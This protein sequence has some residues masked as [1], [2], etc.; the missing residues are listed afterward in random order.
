ML[1]NFILGTEVA[2]IGNIHIANISILLKENNLIEGVDYLKFGGITLLAKQSLQYPK[3]ITELINN[4]INKFTDL[5][6]LVPAK[7]FIDVL[8]NNTKLIAKKYQTITVDSKKFIKILDKDL[9]K[10]M[11]NELITKSVVTNDEIPELI[12][13]NYIVGYIKLTEKK[14]LCWY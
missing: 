5:S 3:Y 10:I 1:K 12:S 9:F 8:E 4:N 2:K 7:Y 13:E 11:T 6:E 14:S